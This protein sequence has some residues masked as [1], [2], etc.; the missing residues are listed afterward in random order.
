MPPNSEQKVLAG[1]FLLYYRH[2]KYLTTQESAMEIF[3]FVR[4]KINK[5]ICTELLYLFINHFLIYIRR[6]YILMHSNCI[7]QKNYIN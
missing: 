3:V 5:N 2:K 4:V 6:L 1:L 7:V